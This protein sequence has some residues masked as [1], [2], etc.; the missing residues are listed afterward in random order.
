MN[1]TI[2]L[3]KAL[4]H[5]SHAV[6]DTTP[7]GRGNYFTNDDFMECGI[8]FLK[9]DGTEFKGVIPEDIAKLVFDEFDITHS[10]VNTFHKSWEKVANADYNQLLVEQVLH[11]MSTYGMEFFGARAVPMIPVEE[12]IAD[13]NARPGYNAIR[14]ITVVSED[15]A[16]KLINEFLMSVKAPNQML[17]PEYEAYVRSATIPVEDICSFELKCVWYEYNNYVPKHGQEFLRY[18]MYKM[19]GSTLIIKNN[20]TIKALQNA[21]EREP[22]KAYDLLKNANMVEL[23]QCFFR[24]KPLFLAFKKSKSCAPI[25]NEIRR[26]ANVFH[27]P[28]SEL[29][30]QNVSKLIKQG[31]YEEAGK[32]LK[33]ADNRQLIKLVNYF[34]TD[35]RV[36]APAVFNI[37]NG[38]I[39]VREDFKRLSAGAAMVFAELVEKNQHSLAGKTFYIPSYIH[40]AAPVSEK[41][42]IGDI[43]YGT[44]LKAPQSG[45]FSAAICWDNYKGMRTDIDLHM[46]SKNASFGWNSAYR[47]RDGEILYSGDMTDA[48]YGAAEA[49]YFEP[50]EDVFILSAN[51]Y[52]GVPNVPFKFFI[53]DAQ[54]KARSYYD[55]TP[56]IDVESAMFPA[57]PL[58]F[59]AGNE[60]GIGI[61]NGCDFYFYGG[62]LNSGIVP[63][64]SKYPMFI[65][66]IVDR[67]DRMMDLEVFI[68]ICGGTVINEMPEDGEI[69][70]D[71]IDLSP[72]ALTARTLFDIVDGVLAKK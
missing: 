31:R 11:Y 10:A 32:V 57:I 9:S 37:R 49:F 46:N 70:K 23:A 12:L 61:F 41:Q 15:E 5:F 40:Y 18:A 63:D 24:F 59:A 52:T 36:K 2:D 60:T 20:R 44:L 4:L 28:M 65:D 43:P 39:H 64:R 58:R 6:L 13:P 34:A 67:L 33:T 71:I 29:T 68:R 66:A 51:N 30:I 7:A 48:F 69:D 22:A 47:G 35:D 1:N 26:L 56:P 3:T 38:K 54:P 14:I 53:S 50:Q 62:M 45:K 72:S 42:M 25:I 8:L 17:M 27:K 21:C 16:Q 19:I 55:V